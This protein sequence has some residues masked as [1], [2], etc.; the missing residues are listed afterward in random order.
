MPDSGLF[1]QLDPEAGSVIQVGCQASVFLKKRTDVLRMRN[2]GHLQLR[3]YDTGWLTV[4]LFSLT[5]KECVK[6]WI[7]VCTIATQILVHIQY[8]CTR[9][10]FFN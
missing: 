2:Q 9:E 10:T 3:F 8:P 6:F 1:E 4:L 5:K 7:L